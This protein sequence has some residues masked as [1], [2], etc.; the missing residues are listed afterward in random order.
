MFH[1]ESGGIYDFEKD[2]ET[3]IKHKEN[4]KIKPLQQ[5]NK[6]TSDS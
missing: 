4:M 5:Y 6:H 1:W 3:A 2:R